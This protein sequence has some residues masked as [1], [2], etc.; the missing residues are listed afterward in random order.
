MNK[1]YLK[2]GYF[3]FTIHFQIKA[4]KQKCFFFKNSNVCQIFIGYYTKIFIN[5]FF[6]AGDDVFG[7]RGWPKLEMSDAVVDFGILSW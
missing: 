6:H 4:K 3:R 5:L 7:K 2:N 1:I